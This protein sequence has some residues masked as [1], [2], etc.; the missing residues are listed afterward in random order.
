MAIFCPGPSLLGSSLTQAHSAPPILCLYD[1]GAREAAPDAV[2]EGLPASTEVFRFTAPHPHPARAA[3]LACAAAHP[4]RDIV[5]LDR[6]TRLPAGAWRRLCAAQ[7]LEFDVVS[8]LSPGLAALDPFAETRRPA[9]TDEADAC[10]WMLSEREAIPCAQWLAACALWKS[11]ALDALAAAGAD[12]ELP[13]GLQ[14]AAIDSLYVDCAPARGATAPAPPAIAVLRER[15]AALGGRIPSSAGRD[16]RPV[17][18]HLLHGWGGGVQR[19]VTDLMRA[20]RQYRHLA[21]VAH[22]S[23][24]RH[25]PGEALA[26]YDDLDAAPLARWPLA[27]GW[28]VYGAALAIRLRLGGDAGAA[29]AV[30][31]GTVDGLSGRFG[32]Q[33]E[34]ILAA[35]AGAGA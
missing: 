13:P 5:L 18:L 4:G 1:A 11:T 9:T 10:V 19:F 16:L 33:N 2:P 15:I 27:L 6:G 28:A 3:L 26:L 22:G 12:G 24:E 32:G 21:L 29:T 17:L 30:W 7:A 34:R 35:C 31:L 20:S 14:A 25:T 8:P 23:S